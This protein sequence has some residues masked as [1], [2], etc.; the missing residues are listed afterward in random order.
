MWS[1]RCWDLPSIAAPHA[2]LGASARLKVSDDCKEPFYG[3]LGAHGPHRLAP[4]AIGSPSGRPLKSRLAVHDSRVSEMFM[5]R[6][7]LTKVNSPGGGNGDSQKRLSYSP[8]TP[9]A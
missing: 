1:L 8:G 7:A 2:L 4:Q 9:P 3:P 6:H 5:N